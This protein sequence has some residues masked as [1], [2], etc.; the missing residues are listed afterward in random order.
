VGAGELADAPYHSLSGGQRQRVLIARAL[1][2]RPDVLLL[3]EPTTGMDLPS[4][5]AMLDLVASFTLRDIA[6]AMVSHQLGAVADYARELCLLSG[7]AHPPEVGSKQEVLTSARLTEMYGQPVRVE[8]VAG[9]STIF[10]E[11]GRR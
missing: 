5:R 4:E 1:V 9:H 11:R 7:L 2:G 3:D 6:V 10:I 8:E